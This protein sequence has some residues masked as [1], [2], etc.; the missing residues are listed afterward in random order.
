MSLA[1]VV[2]LDDLRELARKRLPRIAFDF[3]EGG[4]DDERCL[5]RNR[6][7]FTRHRLVPR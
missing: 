2:Q 5:Q 1:A 6:A 3:I 7:A 4:C